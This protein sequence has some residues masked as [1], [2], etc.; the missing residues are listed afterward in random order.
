MKTL[1]EMTQVEFK[2]LMSGFFASN[3][4]RQKL[5]EAEILAIAKKLNKK[6]NVPLIRETK[7]ENIL[8]KIVL[9]VDNFLYDNLPN[10]FYDLLRSIE[11]GIDDEEA[12]R[13]IN[14]LSILAN[15]KIDIPYIPE[16]WEG[17]ALRFIIGI[18]INAA[19]EKWNI[20]M[21]NKTADAIVVPENDNVSEASLKNMILA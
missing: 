13:L 7:E 11:D 5:T 17:I 6:I 10:E 15:D 9:R 20:D 1:A 21:V 18:I 16:R 12:K 19:R 14:R 2:Q 3:E 8:I 4:E